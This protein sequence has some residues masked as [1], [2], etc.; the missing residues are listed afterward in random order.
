MGSHKHWPSGSI[1]PWWLIHLDNYGHEKKITNTFL[2]RGIP[3]C[4]GRS[5]WAGGRH[6]P[7]RSYSR[8][9]WPGFQPH[10]QSPKE[11]RYHNTVT[12]LEFNEQVRQTYNKKSTV[13]HLKGLPSW[14]VHCKAEKCLGMVWQMDQYHHFRFVKSIWNASEDVRPMITRTH[15]DIIDD[16][17]QLLDWPMY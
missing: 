4:L 12:F 14:Y 10:I 7:F 9:R 2:I 13:T 15:S 6:I 16:V 17:F 8:G 3:N 11:P 1:F 5:Q